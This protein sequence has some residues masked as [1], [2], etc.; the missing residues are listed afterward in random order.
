MTNV[1]A[2]PIYGKNLTK[3]SLEP[4]ARWPWKFV[5]NIGYSSATKFFSND[6]PW[7]TLIYFTTMSK[8]VPYAFIWEKGKTMYFLETIVSML[9]YVSRS[10]ISRLVD[11][12]N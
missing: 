11:A 9:W 2:M 10:M 6:D 12:V 3:S 1:A 8:L 4:K 7:L 5:C